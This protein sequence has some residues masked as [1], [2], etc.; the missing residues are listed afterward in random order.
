MDALPYVWLADLSPPPP[1]VIREGCELL[2]T[3]EYVGPR[4][5][6]DIMG[7]AKEVG[8]EKTYTA[9][10][11]PWCGLFVA[12]VVKRAGFVPVKTPL[13]ARSWAQFG[14]PAPTPS[15]G[16][17]L[18]FARGSGG[19]VGFYVAEDDKAFH[20]LGGNQSNKVSIVRVDKARL[21]AA[22]R[23]PW[24]VAEPGSVKP[25]RVAAAGQLSTNEA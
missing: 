6:P 17:V 21:L 11:I 10:E 25:Y 20:V 19:H 16:D 18:V 3:E 13:W 24:K 7:W 4:H 12:V 9:D 23:C 15:L 5:N 8:L 2:G 22:R 14:N 1:R